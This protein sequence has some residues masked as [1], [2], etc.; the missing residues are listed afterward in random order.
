MTS[1][2]TSTP[3]RF[4]RAGSPSMSSS[5]SED[6]SRELA[7]VDHA[8]SFTV[9]SD[10]AEGIGPVRVQRRHGCVERRPAEPAARDATAGGLTGGS[11]P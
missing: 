8:L 6:G 11:H 9:L 5:R 10:D 4:V 1:G 3:C 2:L 7:R